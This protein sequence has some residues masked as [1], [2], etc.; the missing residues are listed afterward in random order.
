MP[1]HCAFLVVPGWANDDFGRSSVYPVPTHASTH[2]QALTRP[3][4][5]NFLKVRFVNTCLAKEVGRATVNVLNTIGY[6]RLR[7]IVAFL[8]L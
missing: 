8:A 5:E 6:V 4:E 1:L 2:S 7:N 3:K